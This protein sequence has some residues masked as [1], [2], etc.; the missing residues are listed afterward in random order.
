MKS[1]VIKNILLIA[2]LMAGITGFQKN[3]NAA[4]TYIQKDQGEQ[5][6]KIS[7]EKV[8]MVNDAF[9][10]KPQI[11]VPVN[12]KMYYG[13]CNMCV[14]KLNNSEAI[15]TA[16]DPYTEEA[17]DKASA[18]IVLDPDS[19]QDAVLYFKNQ[20]NYLKFKESRKN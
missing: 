7:P 5:S 10:G 2:I 20:K 11:E 4:S 15:R 8:C 19:D 1:I 18:F 16:K 14:G 6:V 17:V 9:M 13:C 12:G 3:A